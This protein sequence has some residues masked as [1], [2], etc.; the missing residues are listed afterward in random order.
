MSMSITST[1][2]VKAILWSCVNVHKRPRYSITGGQYAW[3][4]TAYISSSI[5][6]SW[7]LP[8][9]NVGIQVTRTRIALPFWLGHV[10]AAIVPIQLLAG[11]PV[12]NSYRK[13]RDKYDHYSLSVLFHALRPTQKDCPF[14]WLEGEAASLHC[15][16]VSNLCDSQMCLLITTEKQNISSA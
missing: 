7:A 9:P 2:M 11:V 14:S 16:I 10:D 13:E 4:D 3:L 5:C 1:V 6:G 12:V 8:T 15:H